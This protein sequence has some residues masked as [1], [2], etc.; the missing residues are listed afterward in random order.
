MKG[1][2]KV[3]WR[4]P[5]QVH[6]LFKICPISDTMWAGAMTRRRAGKKIGRA[7]DLREE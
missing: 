7:E 4:Q 3:Y 6:V 5:N 2:A 1:P